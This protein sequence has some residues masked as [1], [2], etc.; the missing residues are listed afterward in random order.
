MGLSVQTHTALFAHLSAGRLTQ[1]VRRMSK[2][3]RPGQKP[4][5]LAATSKA[6]AT[7]I[8][9]WRLE[10]LHSA[11]NS[12]K[13]KLRSPTL[14]QARSE[15]QRA[16][17]GGATGASNE[18]GKKALKGD[19]AARASHMGRRGGPRVACKEV[20][21]HDGFAVAPMVQKNPK[22]METRFRLGRRRG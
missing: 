7:V 14:S 5:S 11:G 10:T 2:H 4:P 17:R 18:K 16:G 6:S 15:V 13:E 22:I 1:E 20:T 8:L 21:R 3:V 9:W 12:R 19:C